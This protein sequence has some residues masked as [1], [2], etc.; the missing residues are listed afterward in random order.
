MKKFLVG[1]VLGLVA[2]PAAAVVWFKA[3]HPSVATADPALPF[4][5]QLVSIPMR[6]RIQR[7]M[8]HQVPIAADEGAFKA[9]ATLYLAQ[10]APCHG[11][12]NHP[13][14]FAKT[15]FPRAPQLFERHGD[16]VGVSDDEPGETYWKVANGIRLTGMPAYAKIL[17]D[18]EMWQVSV[19]LANA[20]K[21]PVSVTDMLKP[22]A[23]P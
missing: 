23:T 16:H 14:A 5:R 21:L 1:F 8:P 2:L 22:A 12:P 10:C 9:G 15:M 19:L 17:K 7:E 11:L 18:T 13:S 3:G 20:D 4:E 6:A